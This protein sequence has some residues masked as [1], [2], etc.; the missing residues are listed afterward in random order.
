[1]NDLN[2][3]LGQLLKN[4]DLTV[5]P[6]QWRRPG[7][8]QFQKCLSMNRSAGLRHGA[9]P[10]FIVP[11][12]RPALQSQGS[13]SQC[14]IESGCGLSRKASRL[15]QY[16]Y[17]G[18]AAAVL[19][20]ALAIELNPGACGAEH[21]TPSG[22]T[23]TSPEE[24]GMDS[25]A[26]VEMF[27]AIRQRRIPMHSIQIVRHGRMALDACFY[28]FREGLRHDVASV[29]KSVSST[30]VGLAVDHG[31]L[32]DVKQSVLSFFPSFQ[33]AGLDA[34]KQAVTLEHLLTMQAGWD[35]GFEPKE[36]RL[37]EMH[38]SADWIK[39]MLDLPMVSAPG[40]RF[41]YCSGNCHVLSAV[42]TRVTGTNALAFARQHLFGPLGIHDVAWPADSQGHN[43]GWGD[44]QLLPR[45]MAKL[46]QLF[47]QRGRWG[48]RQVVSDAWI[49]SATRP[50]VERTTN[51]DRYG[52]FWWVKGSDYPGMFEA[53]GRG[54]QRINVWPAQ[55]LVLVFTG[56]GFEP[57]DLAK[58][59]LKLLKS[60]ESLPPNPQA[61]T[62]LRQRIDDAAKPPRP[63]PVG[64]LP[65]YASLVSG[66]TF[67]LSPNTPG[68]G[69]AALKFDDSPEA[70]VEL[71]WQGRRLTFPVGLD[72][73]E[74]FSMNPLTNLPQAAKGRWTSDDTFFLE[75]DLVGAINCYRLKLK[76]SADGNAL[77][78][79]L[80]E[81]TGL[82][83]EQFNGKTS[84]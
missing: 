6:P 44:L 3:A 23:T 58:F 27:D 10:L 34:S 32:G 84:P 36:A 79:E 66:K 12:R 49:R 76:F 77:S 2:F 52:Y 21:S 16:C 69:S 83:D 4:P 25:D 81:R 61:A 78:A 26:L 13:S 17:G 63:Q 65:K 1:M 40:T 57:G 51:K 20:L 19:T 55:D 33:T 82:N 35:C 47:L 15:R 22:W 29:T 70:E 39:F 41:A 30:L 60:G 43:H 42:L 7:R 56:G 80:G 75:L 24:V 54:G 64:K 48:D 38:R 73:V 9:F 45:D 71:V 74:R 5:H 50:H 68:L 59:I 46:G 31:H 11:C 67:H 28:P 18:R 53:V 14:A 62:R 72:A 37:F 8:I